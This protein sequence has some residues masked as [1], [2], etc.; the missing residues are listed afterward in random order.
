MSSVGYDPMEWFSQEYQTALIPRDLSKVFVMEW[1]LENG[2]E[3]P[4]S[5]ELLDKFLEHSEAERLNENLTYC[6]VGYLRRMLK[7]DSASE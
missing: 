3:L 6:S 1:L 7:R 4:N 5:E 2:V